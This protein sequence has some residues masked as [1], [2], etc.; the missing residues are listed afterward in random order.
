[1]DEQSSTASPNAYEEVPFK[2]S[3]KAI[4][5][6]VPPKILLG[7]NSEAANA[8]ISNNMIAWIEEAITPRER[9]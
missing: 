3:M 4:S 9:T 7:T 1:M 5:N 6:I 8:N 2:D